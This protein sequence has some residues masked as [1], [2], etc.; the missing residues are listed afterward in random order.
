MLDYF[1]AQARNEAR[2]LH[3]LEKR[4]KFPAPYSGARPDFAARLAQPAPI[5]PVIAE[6]KRASPSRGL[7]CAHLEVENVARQYAANGAGCMSVLTEK[8]KF[9]GDLAFLGRAHAAEPGLPLLRKDFIADPLQVRQTAA[10]PA[11]AMLLIARMTPDAKLLRRLRELAGT[12]GL[13]SVVEIFDEKDLRLARESGARLIQVNA[14]DLVNLRVDRS[15]CLRLIERFPPQ[16]DEVWIAASGIENPVQL[17]DAA[18]AGF[19]A[20]LVGSA[21]MAGGEPGK[22]LRQLLGEEHAD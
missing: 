8:T 17:R 16:K 2:K 1:L 11:S 7:I 5:L 3:E 12:Y 22:A 4:G 15:S 19:H 13:E 21:L 9:D 20:A 14:R 18:E 10:T 6:Y